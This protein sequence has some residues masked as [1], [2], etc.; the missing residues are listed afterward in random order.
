MYVTINVL[1]CLSSKTSWTSGKYLRRMR[2]SFSLWRIAWIGR[3][4]LPPL[5]RCNIIRFAL[6]GVDFEVVQWEALQ[7]SWFLLINFWARYFYT[8]LKSEYYRRLVD[9]VPVIILGTRNAYVW[10]IPFWSITTTLRYPTPHF[11]P[12]DFPCLTATPSLDQ[13]YLP[14]VQSHSAPSL[15]QN[16]H[17]PLPATLA[18]RFHALSWPFEPSLQPRC[19]LSRKSHPSLLE[20][21]P[22]FREQGRWH[23]K[24]RWWWHSQRIW[25]YQNSK[26]R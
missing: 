10:N 20:Y 23:R 2:G 24:P 18:D 4:G 11:Y 12:Y 19:P 15:L 26:R 25:R 9:R 6:L 13:R 8:H 21:G 17:C 22:W 3:M 1:L 5:S 14:S 7:K 16:F